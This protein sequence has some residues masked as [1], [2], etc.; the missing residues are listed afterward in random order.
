MYQQQELYRHQQEALARLQ[1]EAERLRQETLDLNF[2]CTKVA[3]II[4][5]QETTF[6]KNSALAPCKKRLF[7]SFCSCCSC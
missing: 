4:E 7:V 2:L 1:D 5:L 6:L 3:E